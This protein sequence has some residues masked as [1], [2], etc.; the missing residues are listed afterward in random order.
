MPSDIQELEDLEPTQVVSEPTDQQLLEELR[1]GG[2]E[3]ATVLYRRYAKRLRQLI[4]SKCSAALARR[5]DADD[6]LQSV[7]HAF[8]KGAKGGCYQVPAGE[9][10]WPL[11]LVIALNKIR[12]QG[13]FHRAAKRDVRLTCGLDDSKVL[14]QSVQE[15]ET[16]E[17]MPLLQL[18]ANEALERI[19]PSQ[20]EIIELRVA[21]HE[22]EQIAQI[23]GRSKRT[24]E[25]ILQSCRQ[26]LSELLE[27]VESHG[28]RRPRETLPTRTRGA[29]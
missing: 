9:E 5:L 15:L 25:R 24:V 16:H 26:Q 2:H 13:S 12:T 23:V 21:G 10:L 4:R 19:P 20:R 1:N 11:L 7:F 14:K 6:I 3:A 27:E 18:V 29:S 22:V 8:F 28:V 17:P